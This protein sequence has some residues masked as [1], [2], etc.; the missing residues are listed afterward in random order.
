MERNEKP[1]QPKKTYNI[2][3]NWM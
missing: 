1:F 2:F 3:N